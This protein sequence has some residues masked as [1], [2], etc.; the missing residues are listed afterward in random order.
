MKTQ[1]E[2]G[3]DLQIGQLVTVAADVG[4]DCLDQLDVRRDFGNRPLP[5]NQRS[6]RFGGAG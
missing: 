3:A 5:R 2:D 1:F 6:A 4:F